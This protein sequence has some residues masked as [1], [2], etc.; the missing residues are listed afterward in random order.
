MPVT[1][2]EIRTADGVMD[3]YLHIPDDAQPSEAAPLPVVILYPDAGGVR[4]VMQEMAARFAAEG[5]AVA[6]TNYF[7]RSGRL[8]FDL[9]TVFGD[10]DE[11]A[12]L[13]A[14]LG[15]ASPEGVVHDTEALLDVLAE[16]GN[17]RSDRVGAVGYCRGGLMAFTMAGELPERIAAAASIHGGGIATD[18]PTSPHLRAGAITAGLYFGV[19]EN[20]RSCTP[21]QRD[22]LVAALEKAGVRYELDD[23]PAGH[24]FAVRDH[25]GAYDE[26][27]AEN[28]FAKVTALFARELPRA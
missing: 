18:A 12:R 21:E 16:A 1:P 24:G 2:L 25:T 9:G 20:D 8:S 5:Y 22:M 28:H 15:E 4:P 17:L 3:V 14:M 6:L 7:Y 27:A 23:V 13:M 26:A 10:P 11:R 19:A